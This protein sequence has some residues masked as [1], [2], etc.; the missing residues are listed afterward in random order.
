MGVRD[1]S[2]MIVD[3]KSVPATES[4]K[5]NSLYDESDLKAMPLV[6]VNLGFEN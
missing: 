3:P 1:L 2:F 5:E 6:P 4:A